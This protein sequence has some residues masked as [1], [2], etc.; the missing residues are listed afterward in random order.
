MKFA[1]NHFQIVGQ[2]KKKWNDMAA[3]MAQPNHN[4]IKCYTLVF[5]N[6]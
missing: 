1:K 4:S 2:I 3:D 6:I 5:S